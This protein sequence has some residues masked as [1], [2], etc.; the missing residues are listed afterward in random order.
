MI[1]TAKVPTSLTRQ[2]AAA[3]AAA[4]EAQ[5]PF[6]GVEVVDMKPMSRGKSLVSFTTSGASVA[7]VPART[8]APLLPVGARY[9]ET[10]ERPWTAPD[11]TKGLHRT[12]AVYEVVAADARG[13]ESVFVDLLENVDAPPT[14]ARV[15]GAGTKH[16]FIWLAITNGVEKGRIRIH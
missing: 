11:G 8:A 4:I 12:A 16:S 9:T 6:S 1:R 10:W 13:G 14:D 7:P 5:F 3:V 15:P 2:G